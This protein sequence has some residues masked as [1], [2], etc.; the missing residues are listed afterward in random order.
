MLRWRTTSHI[1][2]DMSRSGGT[3]SPSEDKGTLNSSRRNQKQVQL[4]HRV[5]PDQLRP[6]LKMSAV[7]TKYTA[8]M[9]ILNRKHVAYFSTCSHW[10]VVTKLSLPQLG[11]IKMST[12]HPVSIQLNNN[13]YNLLSIAPGLPNLVAWSKHAA[14]ENKAT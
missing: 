6:F 8:L 11:L 14:S 1:T 7:S 10:T 12:A 5:L 4:S 3:R 9:G 2:A 13:Q